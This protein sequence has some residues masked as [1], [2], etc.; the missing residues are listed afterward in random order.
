MRLSL[1]FRRTPQRTV[2][3][4]I[5]GLV[6]L[7]GL[8]SS[9]ALA[10]T[11]TASATISGPDIHRDSTGAPVP[12][13]PPPF[14]PPIR[15]IRF[16]ETVSLDGTATGALTY[17]WYLGGAAIDGATQATYTARYPG[18]YNVA[19][20][21]GAGTTTT[22]PYAVS[23]ANFFANMSLRASVSAG[24]N[25]AVLGFTVS[26]P[27]SAVAG[28]TVFAKRI[29][30]RVLGPALAA[31][32]V[33]DAVRQPLL[34]LYD[35]SSR[36]I[37]SNAGWSN[38]PVIG[39]SPVPASP[40][41]PS[42]LV[43][44][45][46]QAFALPANSPDCAL[47]V[48]L[49]P[50]LYTLVASTLSGPG[51]AVAELYS[52]DGTTPSVISNLSA[53]AQV[54]SGPAAAFAG[55]ALRSPDSSNPVPASLLVRGIGP[56]L[57]G[58]GVAGAIANPLV[59]VFDERSVRLVSGTRW[60]QPPTITSLPA[61][62]TATATSTTVMDAVGAFPLNPGSADAAFQMTLPVANYSALLS[63]S[64]AAGVGLVELYFAP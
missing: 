19:A 45:G 32:G 60:G 46:Y 18:N 30:L 3:R 39:P 31:Y 13:S 62:A 53:R 14:P 12:V 50:G 25:V 33:T 8:L 29:L 17:Q 56:A 38:A 34:S 7:C 9:A 47:S 21:N 61:G 42:A 57:T 16:G 6:A 37:A 10:Q 48:T 52:P 36:L 49:P 64:G 4:L 11:F 5:V 22:G 24:E 20:T 63:S 15:R 35:S 44:S 23:L 43:M 59:E 2:L 54:G 51:S 40:Q 1:S 26:G 28:P 55:F 58:F 41:S 27:S